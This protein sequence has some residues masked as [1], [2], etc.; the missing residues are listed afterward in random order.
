MRKRSILYNL[1]KDLTNALEVISQESKLTLPVILLTA[2]LVLLHRY[3]GQE[4]IIIGMPVPSKKQIEKE[5]LTGYF[6]NTLAL[7]TDLSSNPSFQKLL[8]QITDV[9]AEAYTYHNL[10]LQQLVKTA[11]QQH[12]LSHTPLFQVMFVFQDELMSILDL[13]SLTLNSLGSSSSI[14]NFDLILFVEQTEEGLIGTLE[15]N[16]N[17]FETKTL[18][19]MENHLQTLLLEISNNV[20]QN[21]GQIPLLTEAEKHQLEVVWNENQTNYA[22]EKCIHEL[23]EMSLERSPDSVAV[24]F[25]D[26]ILTYQELNHRAN[27]LAYHLQSLGVKPDTL[28]GIC[29]E[30][31]LE[32][33]VGLLGILKAG[34]ACLPLDPSYPKERLAFMLSDSS[35]SILLTQKKLVGKL[36]EQKVHTVYLEMDW[37][38]TQNESQENLL[39]VVRPENIAYVIYTS[40]STGK[41]KGVVMRHLSLANL[42]LWQVQTI[43]SAC[44]ARTLQFASTSF[45]VSFQEIFLTWYSEGTLILVS[46]K[47]RRDAK[48]LL[49]LLLEEA[50]ERLFLPFVALQ[51]LAEAT[52]G[53]GLTPTS[54]REIICAGEQLQMT[55]AITDFFKKL[56]QCSLHNHYGPSESHVVTASTLT[57]SV[58]SWPNL[59]AI[60]RPIANT[61]IYILDRYL[62]PVPIGVSGEL[63]IGG[64]SLATNYLNRPELTGEKFIPNPF[65]NEPGTRLYKTGDLAR[66]LPDGQISYM[67][68]IDNQVKIRGFRIELVEIESVLRQH[69]GVLETVVIARE[70]TVGDKRLVAYVVPKQEYSLTTVNLRRFLKDIIPDYMVPETFVML[71]TLPLTPN[72]KVNRRSLPAPETSKNS[73]DTNFLRPR[74]TLE[75]Q[76]SQIWSDILDIYPV[77]VKD[78]F[79]DLGGHSFIAVRLMEEIE[80]QFQKS[81]PVSTL[82]QNSTIEQQALLI[83]QQ[84]NFQA[85]SPLVTFRST[86][87]QKPFFCI[88]PIGGNVFCY[89]DLARNLNSDQPFYALQSLGLH[90]EQEPFTCI[91]N[92]ADSY[93]KTLQTVQPQGPYYLGGWS[94]GGIIAFEIAQQLHSYGHE[95][96]L[97]ALIDSYPP[98]FFN[99]SQDNNEVMFLISFIKD[100]AR[101]FDKEISVQVNDLQQLNSDEQLNF[102][103]QQLQAVNILPPKIDSQQ[104]HYLLQVFKFNQQAFYSYKL[105]RYPGSISLFCANDDTR[106]I[107]DLK[108]VW[109]DLTSNDLK[110]YSVPGNHYT[111]LQEPNVQ[112]LIKYLETSFHQTRK[113]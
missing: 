23:F 25:E 69:P 43:R 12:T 102:I 83:H 1:S 6:V 7:R 36:P 22:H 97:L 51:Y 4:D 15:Y 109:E 61:Q 81:L 53:S 67:N 105:Q 55:P 33:V 45:D 111:L 20:E 28:V 54:L 93:I 66:Y 19:R 50:V 62:Q 35:V 72:G 87:N 17:L 77:G 3:S 74:N 59:P 95:V 106:K 47:V 26:Q 24:V 92:M 49:G 30:R 76:L 37:G 80:Q 112:E 13:P 8:H 58:T 84:T 10:P 107:Q 40:G 101:L 85:K 2:F 52:N 104:L 60:G 39:S 90:G 70:D 82:F 103:Q 11:Q 71:S 78:D 91:E 110:V 18:L 113:F 9:V 14:T 29:T 31:S 63:Y 38:T 64:V 99:S 75:L 41:P 21:I 32:M 16:A 34:G 108:Q 73:K 68:R 79:F 5:G 57:G 56:P 94:L 98:S 46:E 89:L 48:A 96:A 27:Q 100:I 42:I 65:S 44:S 86:G 88:H